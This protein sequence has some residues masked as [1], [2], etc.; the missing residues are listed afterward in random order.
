[1]ADVHDFSQCGSGIQ[2]QLNWVLCFPVSH[3]AAIRVS[4]RAAVLSEGLAG[5][6]YGSACVV[7]CRFSSF[8]AVCWR[9]LSIPFHVG[10]SSMEHSSLPFPNKPAEKAGEIRSE[11]RLH[12]FVPW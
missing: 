12:S 7:V 9:F 4:V 8:P 11:I 3:R 1:M 2:A 6:G 5:E 10:S